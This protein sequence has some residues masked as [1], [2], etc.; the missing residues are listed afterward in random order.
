VTSL[1]AKPKKQRSKIL[2]KQI[3]RDEIEKKINKKLMQNKKIAIKKI[4]IK[5]NI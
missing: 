2:I 4:R 5:F 1:K 3:L